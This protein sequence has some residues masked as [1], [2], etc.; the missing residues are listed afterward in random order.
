MLFYHDYKQIKRFGENSETN[1]SL[2]QLTEISEQA[3]SRFLKFSNLQIHIAEAQPEISSFLLQ[4]IHQA[5][6]SSQ[7][8]IPALEQSIQEIKTDWNLL[9]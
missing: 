6:L 1:D 7:L 4:F 5:I 9:I 8:K 2:E 3:R